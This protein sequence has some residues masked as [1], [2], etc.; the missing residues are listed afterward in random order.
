MRHQIN[1]YKILHV[2]HWVYLMA[3]C[4]ILG[5]DADYCKQN[6]HFLK[7]YGSHSGIAWVGIAQSV[8]SDTSA[9]E[10]NSFRNHIR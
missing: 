1:H 2:S 8:Y 4:M 6:N 5:I 3:L 9:N 10:D 7:V